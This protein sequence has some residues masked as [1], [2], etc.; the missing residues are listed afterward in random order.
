MLDFENFSW[1]I[2]ISLFAV[3]IILTSVFGFTTGL[4][5]D[6]DK[7]PIFTL[8]G[9]NLA[10][11]LLEAG[12]AIYMYGVVKGKFNKEDRMKNLLLQLNSVKN[13]RKDVEKGFF[14]RKLGKESRDNILTD[15]KQ[16]ELEL[17]NQLELLREKKEGEEGGEET[18]EEEEEE[19]EEE[20]IEKETGD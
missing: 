7:V 12:I 17:K 1:G 15:L 18:S 4:G 9:F 10:L 11:I 5:F 6:P 16:K 13:A 2:I 20:L 19:I 8:L 14:S 3:V